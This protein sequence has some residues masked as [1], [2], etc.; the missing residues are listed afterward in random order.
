VSSFGNRLLQFES[1]FAPSLSA[2]DFF[3]NYFER[4][5]L[6][7]PGDPP[8]RFDGLVTLADVDTYLA[9]CD[10]T[11]PLLRMARAG[12]PVAAG[13]YAKGEAV[14]SAKVHALFGQGATIVIDALDKQFAALA[15]L[16]RS[17]RQRTGYGFHANVYVTPPG[18]QG[19]EV[20]HDT[21]DVFI[22]QILGSKIWSIGEPAI[23]LPLPS[24]EFQP[25]ML[26]SAPHGGPAGREVTLARGDV[27]YLPRGFLHSARSA[28]ELCMHVTLGM[29][30]KTRVEVLMEIVAA[31]GL[32]SPEFRKALPPRC[33]G[34][35]GD[36]ADTARTLQA[37]LL[38]LAR[39]D[40]TD[41][42]R[43]TRRRFIVDSV[44]D[45]TGQLRQ[46]RAIDALT[47]ASIVRRRPSALYSLEEGGGI[48]RLVCAG[49]ELEL[50]DHC[51]GAIR[52]ALCGDKVRVGELGEELDD[53]GKRV[54]AR[55]LAR[56][57]LVDVHEP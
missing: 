29:A 3:E 48:V 57:G 46:A 11:Y 37:L 30:P 51:A 27:L 24:Q 38:C 21:H 41:A 33:A 52:R 28:D 19:F 1:L 9:T 13:E 53:E 32:E 23:A 44:P 34:Q 43:E 50:P 15:A 22:L 4:A 8:S 25:G 18:A 14:D 39:K 36:P 6:H 47:L 20:H 35:D 49:A 7:V 56:L 2:E 5:A 16:C 12:S 54:I 42:L 17:G 55:R 31:A 45:T 10:L 40:L 26:E